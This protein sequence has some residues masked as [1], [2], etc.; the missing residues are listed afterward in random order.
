MNQ[1]ILSVSLVI[2]YLIDITNI[3]ASRA[4]PEILKE[5]ML[6]VVS[7]DQCEQ[8]FSYEGHYDPIP[9]NQLCAGYQEGGKDTCQVCIKNK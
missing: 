7:N 9:K 4:T 5:V 2:Q 6:P 1:T 8:W 3:T